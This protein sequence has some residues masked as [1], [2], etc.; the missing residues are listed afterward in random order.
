MDSWSLVPDAAPSKVPISTET[1]PFSEPS[2]Q[3]SHQSSS[4]IPSPQFQEPEPANVQPSSESVRDAAPHEP[5]YKAKRPPPIE[6]PPPGDVNEAATF[7]PEPGLAPPS[8]LAKTLTSIFGRKRNQSTGTKKARLKTSGTDGPRFIALSPDPDPQGGTRTDHLSGNSLDIEAA[9]TLPVPGVQD[10]PQVSADILSIEDFI[11]EPSRAQILQPDE[12]GEGYRDS[13]HIEQELEKSLAAVVTIP[14]LSTVP[15]Q[16]EDVKRVSIDSASSYGSEG[17]SHSRASSRSTNAVTTY[18]H[19]SSIST[20]HTTASSEEFLSPAF[21]KLRIPDVMPDS[22]TDPC[23]Q[24]GRLTP[25]GETASLAQEAKE[26]KTWPGLLPVPRIPESEGGQLGS[27]QSETQRRPSIPGGCRG[28]CRG[29]SQTIMQ[30]Q[31]SV[32][33]KDGRLTGR[34]HKECFVCKTCRAP[35]A[36]ADFYVHEDDPYCSHDYHLVNG[37]LCESCGNGIEGHYLETSNLTGHGTKKFHPHCLKCVTCQAQLVEDYF[38]LGGRV[39]CEKD[40]F[41]LVHGPRSPY[42]TAPSRPSP[43]NREYISSWSGE[44]GQVLAAGKFPERRLTKFMTTY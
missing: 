1:S 25:V 43:L 38:E 30:G 2:S 18:S 10:V 19:D 14:G 16:A 13:M 7:K 28:I 42:G 20:A 41:R 21:A 36:T 26:E 9:T 29:C 34:Y 3:D 4:E 32:S 6:N 17:F 8:T 24:Q 40:A 37:T 31:K 44:P 35:F 11:P 15:E 23:L 22:P 12:Q 27:P 39:Y 5:S 33:S